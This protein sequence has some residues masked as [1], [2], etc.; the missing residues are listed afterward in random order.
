[1]FCDKPH[2]NQLTSLLLA[3]GFVD[4]V[5]CP[6]S[7]N[8]ILV[9]NFDAAKF[10]L[11]PVTDE[12]SAAFVGL[13]LCLST[14]RPV[15]VCVT[16]GS[17]L[18]NTIPAVAEAYYRQLPLLIISADRPK[19]WINQLDGQ[20]LQQKGA[21]EPYAKTYNIEEAHSP[22]EEHWNNLR[23]NEAI[24]SLHHYG[25]QPVHLNVPIT[26]PLF[27]FKTEHL[28]DVRC[29]KEEY[30][31]VSQ[32][33]SAATIA[34]IQ[35]AKFPIIVIGQYE[36]GEIEA[37]D[38]IESHNALLILPE[39]ISGQ[40]SAWRTTALEHLLPQMDFHP[41]LVIHIGGNLVNK[42]LK[43]KLRKL[44][45]CE[46]IRIEN[47][48]HLPDTFGHLQTIVRST[49]EEVLLQLSQIKTR[50]AQ[51]E[52]FKQNLDIYRN[53]GE[54]Y[55]P[56]HFSDLGILQRIVRNIPEDCALQVGNSSVIRNVAYFFDHHSQ[57][58]FCNRGVNGIEGS[59]SVAVGYAMG[60]KGLSLSLIGDLSFFYDQN[61]LWNTRLPRNLRIVLF[62][63][64]GGQIFYR[65]PG[66]DQTPS[67][68]PYIA[69][70][71][72]T[73]ARGLAESY[74]LTYLSARNYEETDTAISRL[75]KTESEQP[76][77]LE[78]FTQTTDNEN[79][80]KNIKLYYKN[81]FNY[82]K[83]ME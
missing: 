43:L 20:T 31:S 32:P 18:L 3:Q 57:H 79:E 4:I 52:T 1:M 45:T 58:L 59:L 82:G 66:L 53:Q 73:S 70:A 24:L 47:S 40:K 76:M 16:S 2:V 37:L 68:S 69:A 7:R 80:L 50:N 81:L 78:V 41:D 42:Q 51:V 17:A 35:E 39:I 14:H 49:P 21:L 12:R 72:Q 30:P 22:E 60:H 25:N 48:R 83:N 77:L 33:L 62:N 23:M 54:M 29:I 61:A 11:H 55:I 64:G 38:L 6:G 71:H 19:Q 75:W 10:C 34:S 9:H 27:S 63:N 46:V 56:E 13:G 67:L 5:V 8:G 44:S 65:L 74:G 28:P 26:E 36:K 15:A